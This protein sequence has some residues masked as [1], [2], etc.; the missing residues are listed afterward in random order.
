M[1]TGFRRHVKTTKK[2]IKK[3]VTQTD[4]GYLWPEAF[5]VDQ[6]Y[7]LAG[8]SPAE[9]ASACPDKVNIIPANNFEPESYP[10]FLGFR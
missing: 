2:V 1:K 8:C 5:S 6:D 9:P 4:L 3:K 10:Q 7:S